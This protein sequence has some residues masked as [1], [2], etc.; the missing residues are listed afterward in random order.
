MELRD[1]ID[2]MKY[3][4]PVPERDMQLVLGYSWLTFLNQ[5]RKNF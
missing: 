1:G 4:G 2:R 5:V 3:I